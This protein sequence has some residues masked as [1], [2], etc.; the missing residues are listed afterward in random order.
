MRSRA[1][2]QLEDLKAEAREQR[3]NA[4]FEAAYRWT[5][6]YEAQQ[7]AAR[8]PTIVEFEEPAAPSHTP[9]EF[10]QM[11][12]VDAGFSRIEPIQARF[13]QQRDSMLPR[14]SRRSPA[15]ALRWP[16]WKP[17]PFPVGNGNSCDVLV[18]AD[19]SHGPVICL[20]CHECAPFLSAAV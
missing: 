18:S 17:P 3:N 19:F 16:L 7:R 4:D 20:V 13:L 8:G 14:A 1:L 5:A 9:E 6:E 12:A 11:Q 15:K 10:A 2:L